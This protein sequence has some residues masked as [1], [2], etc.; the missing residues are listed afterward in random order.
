M[1]LKDIYLNDI[2]KEIVKEIMKKGKKKDENKFQAE[3]ELG[4][5][6][7]KADN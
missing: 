5:S 1:N 6:V 4:A 7:V 2:K 3:P